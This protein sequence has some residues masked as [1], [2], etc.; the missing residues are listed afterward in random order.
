MVLLRP[1]IHLMNRISYAAKFILVSLLFFTLIA[2]LAVLV[3][4]NYNAKIADTSEE[5]AGIGQLQQQFTLY[6]ELAH[7]RDVRTA[8]RSFTNKRLTELLAQETQKAKDMIAGFDSTALQRFPKSAEQ[9]QE[10]LKAHDERQA[11]LSESKDALNLLFSV[12][13][14]P[15]QKQLAVMNTLA[16]ESGLSRDSDEFTALGV[17]YLVHSLPALLESLS[18]LR[19]Y[20]L[21]I[22]SERYLGNVN[23]DLLNVALFQLNANYVAYQS[24]SQPLLDKG[25][26]DVKNGLQESGDHYQTLVKLVTDEI[27]TA[28]R[29]KLKADEFDQNFTGL[30][31]QLISN[32]NALFTQLHGQ[33]ATRLQAETLRRNI[34]VGGIGIVVLLALGMYLAFYSSVKIA[35]GSMLKAVTSVAQGDLTV[36]VQLNQKDEMGRLS[37][38]FNQMIDRVRDLIQTTMNSSTAVAQQSE[39]MQETSRHA[40][41]V[42]DQQREDIHSISEAIGQVSD[43]AHQVS[44]HAHHAAEAA[45][46]AHGNANSGQRQLRDALHAIQTLAEHIR[47]SATLTTKVSAASGN[48]SQVLDV[49][50]SIAEQTNLLALNAAIEAARAGEQGRGFAVVADEVRLLAQRTQGSTAEIEGMIREL[51]QGVKVAV[52]FME[53]SQKQ[54]EQTVQQSQQVGTTLEAITEAVSQIMAMNHQIATAAEEQTNV[55]EEVTGRIRSVSQGSEQ[56][57]QAGQA[58]SAASEQLTQLTQQLNSAISSFRV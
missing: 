21:E 43:A 19:A 44:E 40:K 11:D 34:V 51:Q 10:V 33:L 16:W 36:T 48:I 14:L 52:T 17:S 49:I 28:S 4:D 56:A 27:L 42:I 29:I 18:A 58:T 5:L 2:V 24:A 39:Y 37:D 53:D 32:S 55:A 3:I 20:G 30:Q 50:K 25:S 41:H 35:V 6:E 26:D 1:L 7:V 38:A 22:T 47:E 9:W 45:S 46:G 15:L 31:Q 23:K 54:A 57:A 13:S 8:F 12:E